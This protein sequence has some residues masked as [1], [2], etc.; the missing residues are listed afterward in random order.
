MN[1][2]STG[3]HEENISSKRTSSV[4]FHGFGSGSL[5]VGLWLTTMFWPKGCSGTISESVGKSNSII[6]LSVGM[7]CAP[8]ST[9]GVS[10]F[11][12]PEYNWIPGKLLPD[13]EQLGE[14]HHKVEV[15][16]ISLFHASCIK[17]SKKKFEKEKDIKRKLLRKQGKHRALSLAE[18]GQAFHSAYVVLLIFYW[19]SYCD[20]PGSYQVRERNQMS[21]PDVFEQNK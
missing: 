18:Q 9:E 15:K 17:W 21:S 7:G 13:V 16:N 20:L 10:G 5:V 4:N 1:S 3:N 8:V 14:D 6:G 12:F 19:A 2:S 11:N